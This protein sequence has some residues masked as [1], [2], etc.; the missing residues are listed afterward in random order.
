[1]KSWVYI[2]KGNQIS[3]VPYQAFKD[4]FE[5]DGFALLGETLNANPTFSNSNPNKDAD[6][7]QIEEI[8]QEEIDEGI[9][10]KRKNS[11]RPTRK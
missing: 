4:L 5:R 8:K 9:S 10:G 2:K 1:M 3:R 6:K 7:E 11:Q